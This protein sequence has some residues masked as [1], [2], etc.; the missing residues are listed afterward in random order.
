MLK[1]DHFGK[2]K[3]LSGQPRLFNGIQSLVC[4]ELGYSY[5]EL[6]ASDIRSKNSLKEIVAESLNNTSITGFY[7]TSQHRSGRA[8]H[9]VSTKHALIMDEVDGMVGNEDRGGI[10]ELTGLIKHKK[11]PIICMCNDRNHPKIHSLV[12]YGFDLSFQRP[13][14]EQIKGAM[15]SIALKE[16]LKAPPPAMNEIIWGANQDI[17]QVLHNVRMWCP[18]SKALTYDQAKAD[19][20][21]TKKDIRLGPF[22]V[23][24]KVFAAG[25]E[26]THMSLVDK[27][28]LF[29]HDYSIA[30]LFVQEN[31]I[32]VK[33]VAAGGDMKKHLMLLS[34]AADG[35]CDGDLVDHQIQSKQNWS[36][37]PT[38]AIYASVL[39]G[40]L[41]RVYMTQF[42]TFPSWLGK[43][44]SISKH[45]HIVQDLALYMSL[46]TD[47]SKRTV[48]VDYLSHIRDAVVQPLTSQGVEGVQDVIALMESYY[49]MKED[50]E[51][52]MEISSWGGKS[53]PFSKL[54]PKVKAAFTRTYSNTGTYNKEV[55]L[56]PYLLQAI[57]TPR[58]STGTAL[59]FHFFKLL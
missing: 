39:P 57:K 59:A 18:R 55:Y 14:V 7:S 10:E 50:F 3:A 17:R 16:G 25:E 42:L 34:R 27:S 30:P 41:M 53:S 49:L 4:Q 15:M 31:D 26:T 29:F 20:H 9:S 40:E 12:H 37:L 8:A 6:N 1:Y 22:D 45:Y 38:Q 46:R 5:M 51:N 23:A 35:L 19:S 21:R 47:S 52:I 2:T 36:L 24:R 54:D 13:R 33:P 28:D 11:I 58:H 44:S 56:T 48:N 43:H 32:H